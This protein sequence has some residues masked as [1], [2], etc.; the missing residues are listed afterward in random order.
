MGAVIH[1][2]D[3]RKRYGRS[4]L[5]L[6]GLDFDVAAGRIVGLMGPNGNKQ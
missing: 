3:V 2:R 6:D 5:A 4:T 1:A